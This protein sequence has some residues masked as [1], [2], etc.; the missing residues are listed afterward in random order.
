MLT[1]DY[2]KIIAQLL[3]GNSKYTP[4]YLYLEFANSETEVSIPEYTEEG[5]E[6]YDS[7]LPEGAGY[8]RIPITITPTVDTVNGKV[9]YTVLVTSTESEN[10]VRFSSADN[11]RIYGVALVSA[12]DPKDPT[13]DV[14]FSRE[15]FEGSKQLTMADNQT[16]CFS[17]QLLVSKGSENSNEM[18]W[19]NS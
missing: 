15:Y 6:Y 10:G 5:R 8:L 7:M 16:F 12:P 17:F 2:N 1:K 13:Q 19:Q 11:S 9:L 14:V 18:E 4:K 3:A